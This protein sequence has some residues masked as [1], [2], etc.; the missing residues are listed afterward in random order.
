MKS[1]VKLQFKLKDPGWLWVVDE[2]ENV[3]DGKGKKT[4]NELFVLS[5]IIE[6]ARFSSLKIEDIKDYFLKNYFQE[7]NIT[8]DGIE[9]IRILDLSAYKSYI[10]NWNP[11]LLNL[12]INQLYIE[13]IIEHDTDTD[14][15]LDIKE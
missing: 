12:G 7:E 13:K 11:H 14:T 10:L 5:N 15:D 3:R 9:K 6:N 4:I 1:I 8:L 2:K